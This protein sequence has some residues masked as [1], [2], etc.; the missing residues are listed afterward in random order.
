MIRVERGQEVSPGIWEYSVPSLGIEG[1]S[2]QPLLDAC[3]KIK[4]TSDATGDRQIGIYREG[5][6]DPDMTCS[7]EIGAAYTVSE[8]AK[9]GAPK[10]VLYR[11]FTGID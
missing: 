5:R 7:V 1:R 10:F 11:E 2:H 8:P 3:R 9:G 6:T 4:R